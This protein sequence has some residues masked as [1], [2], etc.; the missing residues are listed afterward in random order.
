M[1]KPCLR[2][3]TLKEREAVDI[4]PSFNPSSASSDVHALQWVDAG[5]KGKVL[6]YIHNEQLMVSFKDISSLPV[7]KDKILQTLMP[8]FTNFKSFTS[9]QLEADYAKMVVNNDTKTACVVKICN[10]LH[11]PQVAGDLLPVTNELFKKVAVVCEKMI[12]NEKEMD[13]V[14]DEAAQV[15]A[16]LIVACFAGRFVNPFQ[17]TDGSVTPSTY[18]DATAFDMERGDLIVSLL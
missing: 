17:K 5:E 9:E 7:T 8:F 6:I 3:E 1:A 10:Y 15:A 14:M 4:R 11:I 18:K 13:I 16:L 2:L 12:D